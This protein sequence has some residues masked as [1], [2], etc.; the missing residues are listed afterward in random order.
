VTA[1][2]EAGLVSR[3]SR[4]ERWVHRLTG[5]L[6]LVC[7]VTAA[8]L[9]NGSFSLAVGHRHTVELIHVYCGF[10]L[11]V[12]MI[13][14]LGSLAYRADLS[15]LN[16]ISPAD[17]QWL[18]SADLRRLRTGVGKFNAGQKINSWL[19]CASILTL[20][21]TGVIMYFTNW[22]PLSWRTGA[23]FVHDW[24]ALGIGLLVIGHIYRA[25]NDPQARRG[26]RTGQVEQQWAQT[27]HPAWDRPD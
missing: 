26:M 13:L 10:A 1:P 14:G 27:E 9:Y 24:V 22:A 23:T 15:R 19:S 5:V 3:F 25:L 7:I 16:R 2:R 12:P 21:A 17:W 8:I 20:L 18:R 4:A 11:P 6:M